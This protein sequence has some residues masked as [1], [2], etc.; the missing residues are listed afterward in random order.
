[1]TDSEN[2]MDQAVADPISGV[3]KT[4]AVLASMG[5]TKK[6]FQI[7]MNKTEHDE[8]VRKLVLGGSSIAEAKQVITSRKT[9]FNRA[10]R[11]FKKKSQSISNTCKR[12]G[13]SKLS[14][15]QINEHGN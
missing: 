7:P 14:S 5:P 3:Q 15:Q 11:E 2:T 1:M 10:N 9:A 13:P 4:S 8:V 12:T 6:D